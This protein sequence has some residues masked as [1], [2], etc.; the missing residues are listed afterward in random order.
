MAR[1][2]QSPESTGD[3]GSDRM[4]EPS[5]PRGPTGKEAD[6]P[7][8]QDEY[9]RDNRRSANGGTALV[10]NYR[11]IWQSTGS[12]RESP[13]GSKNYVRST[14]RKIHCGT[15]FRQLEMSPRKNQ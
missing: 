15:G 13:F 11:Q 6:V 8:D 2:D 1:V 3:A 7:K 9:E 10:K 14:V 4:I 5:T 12:C